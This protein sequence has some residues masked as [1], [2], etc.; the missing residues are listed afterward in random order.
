[1]SPNE[2]S[3]REK[4][5]DFGLISSAWQS[6][7]GNRLLPQVSTGLCLSITK[8]SGTMLLLLRQN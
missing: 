2:L 6:S 4:S 8:R 5:R 7:R 3:E 1:M